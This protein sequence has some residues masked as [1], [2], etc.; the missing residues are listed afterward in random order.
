MGAALVLDPACSGLFRSV[1]AA[2]RIG[3]SGEPTLTLPGIIDGFRRGPL[4]GALDRWCDRWV[5]CDISAD[6]NSGFQIMRAAEGWTSLWFRSGGLSPPSLLIAG[7]QDHGSWLPLGRSCTADAVMIRPG[8]FRAVTGLPA[9]ELVNQRIEAEVVWGHEGRVLRERLA[10]EPNSMR[11]LTMMAV[12]IDG[13]IRCHATVAAIELADGLRAVTGSRR[14]GDLAQTSGYSARQW[15]RLAADGIGLSPKRLS[16]LLRVRRVMGA[17]F[18]KRDPDWTRL[19]LEHGFCDQSHLIHCW[20]ELYGV[21]P[22]RLHQRFRQQGH[23]VDGL[24]L[25]ASPLTAG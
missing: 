2:Q 5:R 22:E 19:A 15:Q 4:T 7:V 24:V 12:A 17:A 13:R 9:S 8:A 11:R 25:F 1:P 18:S 3:E 20:Q 14:I 21:P 10:A 6:V 23:W 16:L